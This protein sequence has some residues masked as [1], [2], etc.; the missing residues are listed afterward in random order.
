[1]DTLPDKLF[2][3]TIF[4]SDGEDENQ[5]ISSSEAAV[6]GIPTLSWLNAQ[7]DSMRETLLRQEIPDSGQSVL[8]ALIARERNVEKSLPCMTIRKADLPPNM[9]SFTTISLQ[10][11]SWVSGVIQWPGI[12]AASLY[13]VVRDNIAPQMIIGMRIDDIL[14]YSE[15]STQPWR[16]GWSIQPI[17]GETTDET[18]RQIRE[19]EMFLLNGTTYNISSMDRSRLRLRTFRG[20]LSAVVRGTLTYDGVAIWTERD[21]KGRVVSFAPLCPGNIRLVDPEKGYNS[22]TEIAYVGV[23]ETGNVVYTFTRNDLYWS[24]RNPRLEPGIFNYGLSENEV[25]IRLIQ[26]FSQSLALNLDRFNRNSTP[27]GILTLTGPWV[28]RQLNFLSN[29]WI[30]MKRGVSKAWTMPIVKLPQDGKLELIDLSIFKGMDHAIYV[31]F[32]NLIVGALATV[33]RFPV[34]RLGYRVSGLTSGG[35]DQKQPQKDSVTQIDESDIGKTVLLG[36]LEEIINDALIIPNWPLLRMVFHG[37]SPKE[38]AR[39]YEARYNSMTYGERRRA[40]GLPPLSE[41]ASRDQQETV[42]ILELAPG[43]PALQSV[44]QS[45]LIGKQAS[46]MIQPKQDGADA[47]AHGHLAGVR[48]ESRTHEERKI[49]DSKTT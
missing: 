17:G 44:Y 45:I 32:M 19:A 40:S 6:M 4:Q 2:S 24:V 43:D 26:G 30:N 5:L 14:S 21:R 33:F 15:I 27:N 25:G 49:E 23:D 13:K 20:F 12:P 8:D 48:R 42:K 35:S 31:E 9:Q 3:S 34:Q 41:I 37:K 29:I 46:P 28:R 22:D 16:P 7:A 47:E 36:Y 39:A 11:E 10:P 1:M 18:R 38:D